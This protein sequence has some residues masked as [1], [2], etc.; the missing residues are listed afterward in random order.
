MVIN[1]GLA[2]ISKENMPPKG[3]TKPKPT[4]N[5][6]NEANED[7]SVKTPPAANVSPGT[8][9]DKNDSDDS[10]LQE[11]DSYK[12]L[13]QILLNQKLS[14]KKSDERYIKL[15][16][17]IKD[18]K[19]SLDGYKEVNDKAVTTIKTEVSTI[20][21]DLQTL[22]AQVQGLQN[23][24][25]EAN[26]R[27]DTAQNLLDDTR[28]D[29]NEKAR[30]IEKLDKKYEKDEEDLKRCL[31][32][33]D[34][35]NE[36]GNKKPVAVVENLLKDLGVQIKDG[37]IKVAYRLGPLKPGVARPRTIKVQ[38]NKTNTKGEIFKNVG[39]LKNNK[40][41]K[42]IHLNDALSPTEQ[43]QMKDLRCVYAAG[44]AQGIDIKLRGNVL[45]VDGVKLTYKDIDN[46][47]Y[48]LSM[49]SVKI[50]KVADGYAFQSH[51]AY[52]S[53]M[54]LVD[55]VYEGQT[56]KSAEHLYSAEFARHHD[57]TDL[58]QG[59][60]DAQD[61]YDAKR[62]IRNIKTDDSWD[63]VKLKVMR[64]IV[65]LKFDQNDGIRDKLLGT[66]GFLYEATKDSDFACGLT[67]SEAG[68][69]NQ[70]GITGKN[71]LGTILCEYRDERL[72]IK[73]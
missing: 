24:L 1:Y 23:D 65:A 29:L 66:T 53:N 14:E 36:H 5:S 57:R 70:A 6:G 4:G 10:D 25:K 17:A 56:Y 19:K 3:R 9:S 37:D 13:K 64:K 46:L 68:K 15:N 61:G 20:T 50:L 67:L 34:G 41:W 16:K 38:F 55:I 49:E 33:I 42:G 7:D 11:E 47:P 21:K 58:L 18:S 12:L 69:I 22:Q 43:R 30:I 48:G 28:V 8:I 60:I 51:Y 52:L 40:N 63:N 35:V 32:L 62:K 31:L 39:K 45:I 54:F 72:G 26:E 44:R 73:M 27:L 71:M 59:I 2:G